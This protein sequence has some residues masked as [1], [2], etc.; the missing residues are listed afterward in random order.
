MLTFFS[1]PTSL[2]HLHPGR[3]GI[4]HDEVV[5]I[6]RERML[7]AAIQAI[8]AKSYERTNVSDVIAGAGVSR[9]TFYEIFD[10]MEDSFT[11]AFDVVA[12]AT[13]EAVAE[14]AEGSRSWK[15]A[16][17]AGAVAFAD[18]V[19]ANPEAT[20]AC[21]RDADAAASTRA[22][23]HD[24]E[25]RAA[26]FIDRGRQGAPASFDIPPGAGTG[27][28]GALRSLALAGTPGLRM[29]LVY[30]ALAPFLGPKAAAKAAA[31]AQRAPGSVAHGDGAPR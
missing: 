1:D 19:A 27:V 18:I 20:I 11:V 13:A 5:R 6:Q 8:A 10:D 23:L 22:R 17:Q 9:K 31:T 24:W 3:H 26:A 25:Q 12:T 28:A 4:P 2:P 16:V 7:S 15:D 29:E 30:A 21:L 14:A